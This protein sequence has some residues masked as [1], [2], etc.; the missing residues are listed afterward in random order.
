MQGVASGLESIRSCG[1]DYPSNVVYT[2]CIIKTFADLGRQRDYDAHPDPTRMGSYK[3]YLFDSSW[4]H[5]AELVLAVESEWGKWNDVAYDFPKLLIAKAC[6]KILITDS[7]SHGGRNHRERF[8]SG[9]QKM[10]K[11]YPK[12]IAGERYIWIEVAGGPEGGE[13]FGF[14]HRVPR[15]GESPNP[16]LSAAIPERIPYRFREGGWSDF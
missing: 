6:I 2:Q 15:D 9:L 3:E 16:Q 13:L 8:K 11:D 1:I 12:H 10:L 14:E 4:W 5:H 7:G